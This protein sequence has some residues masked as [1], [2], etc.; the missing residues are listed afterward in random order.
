[1][2]LPENK[3]ALAACAAAARLEHL[4]PGALAELRVMTEETAAAEF[5]RLAARYPDTIGNRKRYSEWIAIVRIL[6]ILTEKGD[7]A[8][9]HPLHDRRRSLGEVL[10]D[11]G[12]REWPPQGGGSPR[13]V[14]SERRLAQL[15]TARGPQRGVLLT[16]AARALARSRDPGSGI[17]VVDIACTLL[18]PD[19]R[20]QLAE[21]YYRRLDRA[22]FA[23]EKSHEGKEI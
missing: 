12:D 5:W 14:F 10:C 22:E 3:L 19:N 9:R 16:R 7:P 13:P 6:A 11:G 23:A 8:K 18:A 1:M 15:M 17:N 2:T 4:P 21:P 20:R